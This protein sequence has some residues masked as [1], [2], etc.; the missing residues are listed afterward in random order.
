MSS[1]F[2]GIRW[3]IV[4]LVGVLLFALL[5]SLYQTYLIVHNRQ[6]DAVIIDLAG[7]QRM[8]IER[9]LKQVLLAS[10]GFPV[11][12]VETGRLLLQRI[13]VLIAGGQTIRDIGE[14]TVVTLPPAQTEMIADK[15]REQKKLLKAFLAKEW[16][17]LDEP[18]GTQ[19]S[20][21]A[22]ED[23][24]RLNEAL[25]TVAN[26]AVALMSQHSESKIDTI[27]RWDVI[28]ATIAGIFGLVLT[29]QLWKTH[30]ELQKETTERQHAQQRTLQALRQS[31]DLKSALLSS[32]SHELRTPLT[33]IQ[34]LVS[35]LEDANGDV[36]RELLDGVREEARYLSHLVDNLLDMSRVEAGALRSNRDWHLLEEL[37]EAAI[38]R[39]GPAL[40]QRHLRIDL[41]DS[42]PTVFVEATEL[43]LVFINLLDNAVKYSPERST[44]TLH[45]AVVQGMVEVYVS[46]HGEGI[47][48][49]DTDRVFDRFY[50]TERAVERGISGTGLGLAIC[51][52]IIQAHGGDIRVIS[53][54]EETTIL[55]RLPL[56]PEPL[57]SMM[58][59]LPGFDAGGA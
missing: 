4:A 58:P 24:I 26:E 43:Q 50:R 45:A 49:D 40:E 35:G 42:L 32:V 18:V 28:E 7:R 52:A 57:T 3:K 12:H 16:A 23:A 1:H 38:R 5:G 14:Q 33:A 53:S 17:F 48:P 51:K 22:R 19:G 2:H 21:R 25:V 56:V 9:H 46:N 15:F 39:L 55:F 20:A 13:D 44:I 10:E 27:V 11:D 34:S 47:P 29:V 6:A 41:P 31:D 8:L 59:P 30:H 36:R 37:I 54:A